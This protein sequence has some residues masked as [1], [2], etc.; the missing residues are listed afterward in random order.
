MKEYKPLITKTVSGVLSFVLIFLS[1]FVLF[2]SADEPEEIYCVS[3]HF[4]KLKYNHNS[5]NKYRVPI[6]ENDTTCTHISMSMLLSYYA[7]YWHDSFVPTN[8][9]RMF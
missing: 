3:D 5:N 7:F 1:I 2:V 6:N 4:S 9:L 8:I